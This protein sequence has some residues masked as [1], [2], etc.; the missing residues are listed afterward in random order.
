MKKNPNSNGSARLHLSLGAF[1]G[2]YALLS[3][4]FLPAVA[5]GLALI[6]AVVLAKV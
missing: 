4:S 2:L 3:V 6:A 1:G 5:F